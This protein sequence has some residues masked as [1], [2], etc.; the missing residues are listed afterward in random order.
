MDDIKSDEEIIEF[1]IS[2]EVEARNFFLA[3]ASRV[4]DQQIRDVF[5]QFADEELEHKA[6]LEL[7]IMKTGRTVSTEEKPARSVSEYIISNSDSEL[8]MSLHDA[9]LLAIEKENASFRI[10]INLLSRVNDEHS[11]EILL[12]LAEE[13]VKHKLRFQREYD[14]LIKNT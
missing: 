10:Y 3:V 5:Q 2:R 13:E 1:A 12:R 8:E 14:R 7:E 4:Q 11:R 9:L 6:L